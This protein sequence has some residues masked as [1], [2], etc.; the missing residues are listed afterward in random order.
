[1]VGTLDAQRVLVDKLVDILGVEQGSGSSVAALIVSSP[2]LLSAARCKKLFRL[3][4]ERTWAAHAMNRKLLR[5]RDY[6]CALAHQAVRLDLERL[7]GLAREEVFG[8][9]ALLGQALLVVVA[10]ERI[11]HVAVG[12]EAIGPP[13]FA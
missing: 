9:A 7:E 1:M 3:W 4:R 6:S 12:F 10:E 5:K 2:Q 13:V 11:E 8:L